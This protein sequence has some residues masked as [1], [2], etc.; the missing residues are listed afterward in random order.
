M[1]QRPTKENLSKSLIASLIVCVPAFC[2]FAYVLE[3]RSVLA[4]ANVVVPVMLGMT[5]VD[6]ALILGLE[7]CRSRLGALT[8]PALLAAMGVVLA[9]VVADG[10]S[11]FVTDVGTA[12]LLPVVMAYMAFST[13]AVFK[14]RMLP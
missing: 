1:P 2:L 12:W 9:L 5:A 13:V 14:E 10:V 6:F 4:P 3:T 11:R 7:Y 8:L